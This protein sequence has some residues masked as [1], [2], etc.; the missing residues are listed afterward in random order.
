[1]AAE[2][3]W[4][5]HRSLYDLMVHRAT[6]GHAAFEAEHQS[7][8][9]DPE[10]C[11][12]PQDYFDWPGL[13]FDAWPGDLQ[14]RVVAID[15]SKGKDA[16]HGDYS[17]IVSYGR[18]ASGVEF[19]EADLARRPVDRICADAARVCA[20]FRPDLLVLESNGFQELLRVPLLASLEREGVEVLVRGM[21]NAV[22]KLV[23][24]RRLT[25][26]LERRRLRLKARSPGTQRLL[27]QLRQFPNADHDD[28]PDALEMARRA[29]IELARGGRLG[30]PRR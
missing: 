14:L 10:S 22:S 16:R 8:P 9:V 27:D 1:M 12:W 26:P 18:A 19:A 13:M 30:H 4:P 28:G 20:A 17:A 11:E 21:D 7:N 24:I 25:V 3:L 29:A 2:V 15:P 5:E 23:R 6:I